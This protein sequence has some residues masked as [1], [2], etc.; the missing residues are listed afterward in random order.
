MN[1]TPFRQAGVS[2]IEALAALTVMAFGLIGVAGLQ[3]T[4]R[5]NSDVTKQRAEAVRIAQDALED[6]RAFETV[7]AAT[8]APD[9]DADVDDVA[10]A[11]VTGANATFTRSASVEPAATLPADAPRMKTVTMRVSWEDRT[12]ATQTVTLA[13]AISRIAPELGATLALAGDRAATQMPGGRHRNVPLAAFSLP[14]VGLSV[15]KPPQGSAGTVG[16]VFN[17]L[18]GQVTG[19]CTLD[20]AWTNES[21]TEAERTALATAC[22]DSRTTIAAQMISGFVRFATAGTTAQA[23]EPGGTLRNLN[24][25]FGLFEAGT[26]PSAPQCYD[27]ATDQTDTLRGGPDVSYY[28]LVYSNSVGSLVGRTRIQPQA[29]GAVPA[30]SIGNSGADFKVCRYT[31]LVT[32]TGARNRD[33]P[34]DYTVAGSRPYESLVQQNFLVVPGVDAC[35]SETAG[36]DF[37]NSNT[38]LHQ[39]GSSA[40]PNP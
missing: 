14:G 7:T 24:L 3:G 23:E 12:G 40:Y 18:T 13:S 15:F 33:H 31:P 16:W 1:T 25:V 19:L 10:S 22:A 36:A 17:N 11:T 21:L 32:D 30:W 29:Y 37:F 6:W 28:C 39:D 2:L 35:P 5:S 20:A 38:R 27:D 4:L 8:G 26:Y 9:F 34:L